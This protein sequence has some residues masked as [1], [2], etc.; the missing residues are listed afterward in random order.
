MV[1]IVGIKKLIKRAVSRARRINGKVM[2]MTFS[3]HP[4]HILCPSKFLPLIVS[5]EKR[6]DILESLGVDITFVVRFTKRFA[7]MKPM[8]FMRRYIVSKIAPKEVIVGDDFRFG[9]DKCGSLGLLRQTGERYGFKVEGF[10]CVKT[11]MGKI[12]S[13]QIRSCIL[14]GR[15]KD[16]QRYLGRPFTLE[17]IVVKG[18]S[19]G[20]ELG[21]PTANI[22]PHR[23][24]VPPVGVYVV[25]V[26]IGDKTFGG[27]ANV[28]F[29]PSFRKNLKKKSVE[30][31]ILN[32]SKCIYDKEIRIECLEFMRSE[33]VFSTQEDLIRQLKKDK[34]DA[35]MFF[36]K[37]GCV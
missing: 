15:F 16:A 22:Y 3:P 29:C 6:L 25:K 21:F 37:F 1:F 10:E 35:V 24:L 23:I 5:L 7:T 8:D 30:V 11:G 17:G 2:I 9:V 12:G 14:D 20:K 4:V 18:F 36:D 26:H 34:R 27:M 19:R 31:Y 32:F 28:G 33:R 13:T